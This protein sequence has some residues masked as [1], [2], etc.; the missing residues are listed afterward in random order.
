MLRLR[1]KEKSAQ[2]CREWIK[3]TNK[4]TVIG[5][6]LALWSLI[7]RKFF[8]PIALHVIDE[9]V[10]VNRTNNRDFECTKNCILMWNFPHMRFRWNFTISIIIVQHLD[11]VKF[12]F[13]VVQWNVFFN[14]RLF[15]FRT[16]NPLTIENYI[17][18]LINALLD[19]IL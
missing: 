6:F 2:E 11:C 19:A 9:P 14:E 8:Q 15:E 16:N 1:R 17:S 12:R 4:Q 7:F 5:Q 13:A 3:Q 10:I 18:S